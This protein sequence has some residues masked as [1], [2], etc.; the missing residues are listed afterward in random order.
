MK[1]YCIWGV[2][3]VTISVVLYVIL[4][5]I[6]KK[7]KQNVN[8]GQT[9]YIGS[10]GDTSQRY[11]IS[12][13]SSNNEIQLTNTGI[14]RTAPEGNSDGINLE[15]VSNND[16]TNNNTGNRIKQKDRWLRSF[17]VINVIIVGMCCI[18]FSVGA[19]MLI[20]FVYTQHRLQDNIVYSEFS[21]SD[22]ISIF[23]SIVGI[24]VGI[25][26]F[27][28]Q[29]AQTNS[30]KAEED[31]ASQAEKKRTDMYIKSVEDYYNATFETTLKNFQHDVLYKAV[32]SWN[33]TSY[34][35]IT[36]SKDKN[37]CKIELEL[38]DTVVAQNDFTNGTIVITVNA[39]N[40]NT[41]KEEMYINNIQS[42][43]IEV[44]DNKLCTSLNLANVDKI[45][46]DIH[47]AIHKKE[48]LHMCIEYHDI[49]N[50]HRVP[51]LKKRDENQIAEIN[52]EILNSNYV[53]EYE[54]LK[55]YVKQRTILNYQKVTSIPN[56]RC[57]NDCEIQIA[58]I[59]VE[60]V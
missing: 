26:I 53:T 21:S 5:C 8:M 3:L 10:I 48:I 7:M 2:F 58:D 38:P 59:K 31:I 1:A 44:V 49:I 57:Y 18:A 52:I 15:I 19:T 46:T 39:D 42:N 40:K 30:I 32:N 22:I 4:W 51:T 14:T 9:N 29:W 55:Y 36:F 27:K 37:T 35:S 11:S 20:H 41:G 28:A 45:L 16:S 34:K 6:Q 47:S 25:A 24:L 33:N 50:I 12:H 17:E 43:P 23:L 60:N 54:N 13:V 56:V